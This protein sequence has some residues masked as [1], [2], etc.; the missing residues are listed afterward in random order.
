MRPVIGVIGCNKEHEGEPAHAVKARYIEGVARHADAA[1]LIVPSLGAPDDVRAI[2]PK[3][4]GILLT[5]ATSNMEPHHFGGTLEHGPSD[6]GRDGTAL[7]LI[8]TAQAANVPIIGICRGFQEINVALGG[9][10]RDQRDGGDRSVPHHAPDGATLDE[11]FAHSHAVDVAPGS[12]LEQIAGARELTVNS[13]HYQM[14]DAL[15]D[16][17]RVEARARDGVIEAISSRDGR[18]I[19]AVQWHPEWRPELRPH[20][21]AFWH[22]VGTLVRGEAE[23][24]A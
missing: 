13:V 20:D 22:H 12:L 7:A 11:Q 16:G 15:G 24:S 21:I 9:T 14:I 19:F 3:L 10:L 18:S 2:V 6:P 4:D 23:L 8:R 1:A 17:L 5:G